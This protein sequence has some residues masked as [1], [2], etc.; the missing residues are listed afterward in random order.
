MPSEHA[1]SPNDKPSSLESLED[2][3]YSRTPPPLRH[4][5]EFGSGERHIR[6]APGWTEEE[7]RRESTLYGMFAKIMPVLK[8]LFIASILFF[9]FAAGIAFYGFWR[10]GNTISPQN[11]SLSLLGPV[12]HPAGEELD[13]EVTV[14]NYNQLPLE[15]VDLLVEYPM[16]TRKPTDMSAELLRY[17]EALGALPAGGST[18]R[19]LAMVPFGEEGEK[20]EIRVTVEYRPK[21]S[22]AIFPQTA[23]YEFLISAAPVSVSVSAPKEVNSGQTFEIAL[24]I[25]S[26]ASGV[27]KHLLVKADYPIGFSFVESAPAAAFSKDTWQLGDLPPQGKRTL[28]LVGRIDAVLEEERTFRIS[29]GT[30]SPKDEK[31][32]GTAF[33]IETPSVVVKKPFVS[34]E[35][36]LNGERGKT[37]VARSGQSVRADVLWA[38]NLAT[39]IADLEITAK[40]DGGIYNLSSVAPGGGFYDSNTATIFWDKR[41]YSR[42]GAVEPGEEGTLSFSFGI[43]PVAIDPALFKNPNMTIHL[44]ARGKRLD[45]TGLFQQDV[46]SSLS[47]EVK[48]ASQ[49]NFISRLLYAGGAFVNSGPVPPKAEEETTYTVVWSLSNSSNGVSAT[50]VSAVL[51]SYVTWLDRV[52]PPAERVSYRPVG[53][54]V[55]WDVGD[56]A[57][58]VGFGTSPR[59]VSFQISV[60]PSLG[61]VGTAPALLGETS[62]EGEDRFT[63]VSV[64]SNVRPALSTA[65]LGDAGGGGVVTK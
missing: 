24:E 8:R 58:G 64:R 1:S 13:F 20:K 57:A 62:A 43:L 63:G 55:V 41:G 36:A 37:F 28:R 9:L 42:F 17:R 27:I 3:L 60:R 21:D 61:Q 38:N 5:E 48:I 30:E 10:G 26:N 4:D 44:F 47:K 25:T 2:R 6:I 40:L 22:N 54:E 18:S 59:E 31:L 32:L 29:V 16:G 65:S 35:L 53:G 11:I 33:L 50:R 46:V 14:G 12:S 56:I 39:K 23:S 52:T 45:E 49:L 19:K 51:P 34:L 15:S 7:E